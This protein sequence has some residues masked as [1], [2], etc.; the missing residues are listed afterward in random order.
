YFHGAAMRDVPLRLEVSTS[1]TAFRPAGFQGYSFGDRDDGSR[2]GTVEAQL[3]LDAQGRARFEHPLALPEVRVPVT[4]EFEAEVA[5]VSR[6]FA[7]EDRA[8]ALVHPAT[9]YV[10]L[11]PDDVSPRYPGRPIYWPTGNRRSGHPTV[12]MGATHVGPPGPGHVRERFPAV[13]STLPKARDVEVELAVTGALTGTRRATVRLPARGHRELELELLAGRPGLATFTATAR[14]GAL[15]D[16]VR[17]EHRVT[18]PLTFTTAVVEG[19]ARGVAWERLGVGSG[20]DRAD[21][22]RAIATLRSRQQPDGGFGY[23]TGSEGSDP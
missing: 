22:E 19:V 11:R 1:G 18:E 6:R 14:S 15:R 20:L 12:R 10:G 13:A 9:F 5:D 2:G 8:T 4:V 16:A 7:I 21:L 17:I 3:R 23:W